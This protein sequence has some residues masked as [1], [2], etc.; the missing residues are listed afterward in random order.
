MKWK[1]EKKI[2]HGY[3][4]PESKTEP[5]ACTR[6]FSTLDQHSSNSST[7]HKPVFVLGNEER[8]AVEAHKLHVEMLRSMAIE[9][10][11]R[12]TIR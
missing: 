2:K 5:V 1:S 12:S 11:R 4:H 6:A 8:R 9:Y 3:C 10:A 7:P